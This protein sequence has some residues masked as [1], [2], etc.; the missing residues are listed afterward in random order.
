MYV[1]LSCQTV[2]LRPHVILH[3]LLDATAARKMQ[4]P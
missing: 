2:L 1:L 3:T 4:E